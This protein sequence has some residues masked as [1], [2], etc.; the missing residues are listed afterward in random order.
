MRILW[1][2]NIMLPESMQLLKG[3]GEHKSSG[4]WMIGAANALSK[5]DTIKLAIATVSE[6]V[7]NLT[8]LCGE[9]I[10]YY[11]LPF[12]KGNLR[13]NSEYE[14][15]WKKVKEDF[16][17]DVVHIHGTEF[18][19]G[20]AYINACGSE[21]V[22]VSIQGMKSAYYHY[23]Y[24]GLTQ[25]NIIRNLTFNDIIRGSAIRGKF[26]FKRQSTYEI[27][28]L[29]KVHHVIGRTSWDKARR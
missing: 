15:Y 26:Q 16:Q 24:S 17:P 1:I 6:D 23:F 4:G 10:S 5:G 27:D 28:L 29:K 14:P 20:L 13:E 2:T 8:V 9:R 18:S 21:S 22:V 12:G 25:W 3:Y 7:K 19:H 11:L